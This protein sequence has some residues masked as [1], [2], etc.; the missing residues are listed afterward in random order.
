M[1][2]CYRYIYFFYFSG[3]ILAE[4]KQSPIDLVEGKS[5][6]VSG[7]NMELNLH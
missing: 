1:E 2:Y 5:E 4:M 3:R 6:L 7:F